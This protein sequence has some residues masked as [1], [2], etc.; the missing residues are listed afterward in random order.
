MQNTNF[1]FLNYRKENSNVG[2]D[3]ILSATNF[4]AAGESLK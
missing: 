1:V 3:K 4:C 2:V